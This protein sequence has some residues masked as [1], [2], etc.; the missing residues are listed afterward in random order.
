M[1]ENTNK[2]INKSPIN[3]KGER[4]KGWMKVFEEPRVEN[5]RK[6]ILLFVCMGIIISQGLAIST[7]LPLEKRIPYFVEVDNAN[8]AVVANN[9]VGQE[10]KPEENN[11]KYF[12]NIWIRDI[13]T[14]DSRLTNEIYFPEAYSMTRGNA[15]TQVRDYISKAKVFEGLNSNINWK[16]IPKILT[17][18]FIAPGVVMVRYNIEEINGGTDN[19]KKMAA[20]IHYALIPPTTEI[21]INHNPIGFF[22]TDFTINEELN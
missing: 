1:A 9:K 8:G 19:G 15:I 16:R 11:I 2:E 13:I 4:F 5:K 10:F 3:T 17:I 18:S 21:E 6:S 7:M 12:L 22:V 20:T 14:I